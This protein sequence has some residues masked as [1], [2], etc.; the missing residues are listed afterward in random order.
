MD[1]VV[2]I[3]RSYIG[4]VKY[5]FGAKNPDEGKSD[6]SGFTQHVFKKAGYNIAGYTEG[7]WTDENL[8]NVSKQDLQIGDL[9]LFKNTYDS[10]YKDGV[11]HIGIYSGNGKFI[12][13][14]SD[15]VHEESL[16]TN[17]WINHYLGAKRVSGDKSGNISET[18]TTEK[19]SIASSL[20]LEW[21]GDVVV[22]VL[23]ILLILGGIVLLIMGVKGSVIDKI[24]SEVLHA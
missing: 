18:I 11:S 20:G 22:V 13:C 15:G 16:Y 2:S 21:W 3:A 19:N 24:S 12:H 23:S 10:G 4:K 5:V 9:V 1:N 7:V 14:G 6:C 17:Y 8:A